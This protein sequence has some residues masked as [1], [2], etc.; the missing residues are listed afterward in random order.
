M[1]TLCKVLTLDASKKRPL[2]RITVAGAGPAGWAVATACARTGIETRLV[3]PHLSEPFPASYGV[4]EDSIEAELLA[5]CGVRRFSNPRVVTDSFQSLLP[6]AYVR[7][8]SARL[9]EELRRRARS[10]GVIAME[11]S[12]R[13]ADRNEDE[14][15]IDAT[16]ARSKLWRGEAPTFSG[17]QS[18]YGLWIRTEQSEHLATPME[19]MDYRSSGDRKTVPTFLYL[20]EEAPGLLFVQETSLV[21]RE[22]LPM[23]R[24]RQLLLARLDQLGLTYVDIEKEEHCVIP[25]GANLPSDLPRPGIVPFG[26]ACGFVHP[27]TGYQLS[28]ALGWA[29][30]LARALVGAAQEGAERAGASAY[31]ALWTSERRAA[32]ELYRVGSEVIMEFDQREM[33]AFVR[34]FFSLPTERWFGFMEGTLDSV[35]ILDAMWRVFRRSPNSLRF[36]LMSSGARRGCRALSHVWSISKNRSSTSLGEITP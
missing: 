9:G 7:L 34:A 23:S 18:A 19:L 28:R 12:I 21:H 26:A 11:G 25:M 5:A 6:R 8:D 14:V 30:P 27:A 29:E 15:L 20:M 16:G 35:A 31:R 10:A 1:H 33:E 13:A 24:L 32:W 36:R 17:Y 4:W 3:A 2:R 22:P